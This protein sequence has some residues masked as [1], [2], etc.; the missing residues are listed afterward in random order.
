MMARVD[1]VFRSPNQERIN[2]FIGLVHG[3]TFYNFQVE[4]CPIGGEFQ[5]NV[6]SN[7][8]KTTFKELHSALTSFLATEL[9]NA[10]YKF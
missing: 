8:P 1:N 6:T 2:T 4:A 5:I 3:R 10:Y 7:R 9:V